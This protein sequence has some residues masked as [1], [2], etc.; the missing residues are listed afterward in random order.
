MHSRGLIHRDLKPQ[1]ILV[2]NR[3]PDEPILKICDMGLGRQ[4]ALPV[5]RLTHEVGTLYYRSPEVLLG[6]KTYAYPI[7]VWS[8]GC[9]FAEMITK[10]SDL[11]IDLY[12]HTF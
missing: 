2:D 4:Q 8:V 11:I 12:K 9:T 10:V 3:I 7:D 1:N 6:S 5:P